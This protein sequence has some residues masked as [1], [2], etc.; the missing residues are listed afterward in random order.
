M[1]T[2]DVV[3]ERFR[4]KEVIT[5][6]VFRVSRDYADLAYRIAANKTLCRLRSLELP[7]GLLTRMR[8]R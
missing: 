3:T 5:L 6:L 8:L 4:S 1:E 2:R 7:E